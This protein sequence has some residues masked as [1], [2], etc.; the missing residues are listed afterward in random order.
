MA[1]TETDQGCQQG[2]AAQVG[3]HHLV[4]HVQKGEGNVALLLGTPFLEKRLI[5]T[6]L[7]VG[8]AKLQHL[9]IARVE[10]LPA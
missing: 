7:V 2:Q 9:V 8:A 6:H 10:G 1:E 3:F 5:V 4:N